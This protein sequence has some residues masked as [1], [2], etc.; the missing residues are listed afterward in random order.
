MA[1]PTSF[2]L[3]EFIGR[4]VDAVQAN[5]VIAVV[6]ALASSYTRGQGFDDGVPD[7]LRAVILTASARRLADTS[8]I[9]E[10][11]R[12]GPFAVTYQPNGGGWST[13]E[14]ATLNRYRQRAA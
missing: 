1:A 8:G 13:S 6:T 14:L 11:Q 7:D 5:A 2:D 9:V 4:D 10:Q 12:M 3:A